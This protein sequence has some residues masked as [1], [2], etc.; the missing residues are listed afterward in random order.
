MLKSYGVLSGS[1]CQN[2][3]GVSSKLPTTRGA[4]LKEARH[5]TDKFSASEGEGG[6]DEDGADALEAVRE[7]PGVIE[8]TGAVVLGVAAGLW[9]AAKDEDKGGDEEHGDDEELPAGRPELLFGVAGRE[10]VENDGADGWRRF[11]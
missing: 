8:E 5:T 11:C 2:K 7:G 10:N 4:L 9:T 6:G 1:D 3:R